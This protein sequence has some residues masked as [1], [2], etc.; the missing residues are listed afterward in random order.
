MKCFFDDAAQIQAI[1]GLSTDAAV[2]V[3]AK[4]FQVR[5]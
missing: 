4:K 2:K 1:A 5:A 3:L